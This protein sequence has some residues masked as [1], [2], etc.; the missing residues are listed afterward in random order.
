MIISCGVDK[1]K[2]IISNRHTSSELLIDLL[3]ARVPIRLLSRTRRDK[4]VPAFSLHAMSSFVTMDHKM[5]KT[6][7]HDRIYKLDKVNLLNIQ[8]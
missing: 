8:T 1:H 4:T 7:N 3:V 2:H 5:D 6:Y